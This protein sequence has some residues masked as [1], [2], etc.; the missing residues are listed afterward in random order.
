MT[1][2]HE[3]PGLLPGQ[4]GEGE[5]P[6]LGVGTAI[7]AGAEGVVQ[8]LVTRKVS[9]ACWSWFQLHILTN[10]DRFPETAQNL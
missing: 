10:V 8:T 6:S 9:H 7:G 1:L 3:L 2:A 4:G 5:D